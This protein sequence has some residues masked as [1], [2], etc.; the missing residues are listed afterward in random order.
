M[1]ADATIVAHHVLIE[2][3]AAF[4]ILDFAARRQVHHRVPVDRRIDLGGHGLVWCNDGVEI[5][6]LAGT[7]RDLLRVGKSVAPDPDLIIGIRKIR[8]NVTALVVRDDDLGVTRIEFVGLGNNP[9]TGLRSIGARHDAA[10]VVAIE[11]R[12]L[13]LCW[14]GGQPSG[15]SGHSPSKMSS[16]MNCHC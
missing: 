6:S 2:I 12:H 3:Q 16:P 4:E 9:D 7:A 1:A 8:H 13:R 14:R 10:D 5:V 15:H 11:L